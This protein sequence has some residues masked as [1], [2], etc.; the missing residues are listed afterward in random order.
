MVK[1]NQ[2]LLAMKKRGFGAGRWNGYGGSVKEKETVF[3]AALREI[4]EESAVSVLEDALKKVA[5]FLFIFDGNPKVHCHIFL[6]KDWQGEPQDS[7]EMGPHIWFDR[8][9]L[10]EAE[11]WPADRIWI[12]EVLAGKKIKGEIHFDE[13]GNEVKKC[14]WT[15]TEF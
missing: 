1:E 15:E 8:A 13:A 11:M 14:D 10:P 6:A 9:F 3:E 4:R 12:P 7:E 2:I 5:E